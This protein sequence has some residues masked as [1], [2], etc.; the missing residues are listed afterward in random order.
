[1]SDIQRWTI[2]GKETFFEDAKGALVKYDDHMKIC[3][4]QEKEL[5]KAEKENATLQARIDE[6][7]YGLMP[8]EN[9]PPMPEIKPVKSYK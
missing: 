6:L 7:E 2:A 8:V 9:T 3:I 4:E 1:M 5:M